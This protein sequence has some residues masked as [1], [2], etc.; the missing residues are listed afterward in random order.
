MWGNGVS[1][2]NALAVPLLVRLLL[3]QI[4]F[5]SIPPPRMH[6]M[7]SNRDLSSSS[8]SSSSSV[9]TLA[10]NSMHAPFIFYVNTTK[11]SV[12]TQRG[13]IR[14]KKR[15]HP[16]PSSGELS[17]FFISCGNMV[18]TPGSLAPRGWNARLSHFI[19]RRI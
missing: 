7:M 16:S 11:S 13:T 6:A 19:R 5:F 12:N 10:L 14:G 1:L 18:L 3:P 2:Y 4:L 9:G 17:L 8:S 15:P